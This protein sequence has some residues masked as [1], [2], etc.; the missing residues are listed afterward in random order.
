MILLASV[1][2]GLIIA[3]LCALGGIPIPLAAVTGLAAAGAVA[4][5]LHKI[6]E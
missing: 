4:M 6:M 5:G 3:G 1:V 2:I